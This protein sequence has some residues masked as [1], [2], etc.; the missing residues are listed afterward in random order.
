M[1]YKL[2][3]DDIFDQTLHLNQVYTKNEKSGKSGRNN[4]LQEK[5]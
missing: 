4:R 3:N 1:T 5:N 2:N